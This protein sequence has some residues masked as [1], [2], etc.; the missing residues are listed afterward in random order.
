MDIF[1][2]ANKPISQVASHAVGTKQVAGKTDY[3]V[4]VQHDQINNSQVKTKIHSTVKELN[5]HMDALN[6]NVTFG[7]ND[8]INT[9]FVDVMEKSTGKIIRKIP[10]KEAMHLAERMKEIVGIIFDKK[11]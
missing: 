10:T 9:M 8:K 3:V 11:G 1:N 5:Q 4:H 7:Y 6:T 2:V